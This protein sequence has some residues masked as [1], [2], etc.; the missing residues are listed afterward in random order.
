[1][2]N[3]GEEQGEERPSISVE[4][5]VSV[6]TYFLGLGGLGEAWRNVAFEYQGEDIQGKWLKLF[7][8]PRQ[9]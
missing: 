9:R 8:K 7:F 5:M 3:H 1:M 4:R 2:E 6:H